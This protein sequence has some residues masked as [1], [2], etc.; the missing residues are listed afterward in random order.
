MGAR[1]K[2]NWQRLKVKDL[3]VIGL[4]GLCG[5]L[6]MAVAGLLGF[7]PY[8]YLGAFP[9]VGLASGIIYF[10]VMTKVPKRGAALV[11]ASTFAFIY[12]M[13]GWVWLFALTLLAGLINEVIFHALG[14]DNRKGLTLAYVLSHCAF[15]FGSYIPFLFYGQ[16]YIDKYSKVYGAEYMEQSVSLISPASTAVL[17]IVNGIAALLGAWIAVHFLKKHF[18]KAG[19]V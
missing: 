12:L 13:S 9:V 15:A 1:Q 2:K 16:Q 7:S 3:I 19:M 10:L 4:L 17:M 18:E 6:V 11:Y 8:T 14:Y 5:G